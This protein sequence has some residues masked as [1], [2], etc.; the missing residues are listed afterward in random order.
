MPT[1]EVHSQPHR[2]SI[3]DYLAMGEAGILSREDRVELIDGQVVAMSPIGNPHMTSVRRLAHR[4]RRQ[5]SQE[6]MVDV[7]NGLNIGENTQVVPD[8]MLVPTERI[9]WAKP[10]Q[11]KDVLLVVEVA[12]TSLERDRHAKQGLYAK[13]GIP[14]YWIVDLIGRCLEVYRDPA[15]GRYTSRTVHL[16]GAVVSAKLVSEVALPVE[17]VVPPELKD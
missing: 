17:E 4:L 11:G 6:V 3:E 2:F 12:D 16:P 15:E 7:Q 1:L 10:L 8:L 14:E 13:S 5:V 9:S